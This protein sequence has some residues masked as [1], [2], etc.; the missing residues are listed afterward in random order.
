[1]TKSTKNRRLRAAKKRRLRAAK[2]R[3][4]Q[5]AVQEI[6]NFREKFGRMPTT[7]DLVSLECLCLFHKFKKK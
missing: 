6:K 3:R 5:P 1:M 7:E 2:K 4:L